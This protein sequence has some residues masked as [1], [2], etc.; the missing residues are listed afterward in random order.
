MILSHAQLPDRQA[1]RSARRPHQDRYSRARPLQRPSKAASVSRDRRQRRAR[2]QRDASTGSLGVSRATRMR[3]GLSVD[4]PTLEEATREQETPAPRPAW[5]SSATDGL[6]RGAFGN[7]AS[8]ASHARWPHIPT[9]RESP[10]AWL[11]TRIEMS[12]S[13]AARH[14]I[15]HPQG[16]GFRAC[17]PEWSAPRLARRRCLP[18]K[19]AQPRQSP[20]SS[21]ACQAARPEPLP[22]P[23]APS[24]H[25]QASSAHE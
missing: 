24:R 6:A 19:P 14:R 16:F 25:P 18:Q 9:D 21:R 3:A 23:A 17:D 13:G 10:L 7:A 1:H 11:S 4:G 5:S 22:A 20:Q 2:I 12:S 8:E 15:S